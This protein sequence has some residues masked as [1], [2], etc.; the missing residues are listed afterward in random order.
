MRESGVKKKGV[1]MEKPSLT[2]L[3][4]TKNEEY[5][6]GAAIDNVADVAE[7]VY[8]VDSGSTD[9]TVEIAE[10]KGATVVYHK[11]E[12]F[13]A[14]W[15]F[16]L[17]LPIKTAWTM[18][19]DPDERL[20]ESLKPEIRRALKSARDV[21]GFEFDRVLWFMGRPMRGWKDCVVRIWRTGSCRFTTVSVNEHPI[22]S[23]RVS[24][25]K[26]RMEHLDSRDLFHWIDKQNKYTSQ[27]AAA[28]L[29]GTGY[30]VRPQF[31]GTKLAR[32]MWFK[33]LFFRLPFRYGLMFVHLYFG[34]S[35]WREGWTGYH[36]AL[37]R[38]WA[39][40]LV[41]EKMLEVANAENRK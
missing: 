23:G 34:K 3:F 10:S 18:K 9:R 29:S 4:I 5:H 14:Q 38:I 39:R 2:V 8:V 24:C 28:R 33:R 35:L 19:M 36:C 26:G 1:R 21:T 25:L 37:L 40:R 11:F 15:N 17:S 13:G 12:G 22:V 31:L 6:I 7:A 16:A 27:A 20:S 32:R 41:E 30:A